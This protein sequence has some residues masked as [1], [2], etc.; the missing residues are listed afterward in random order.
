MELGD[1]WLLRKQSKL[2]TLP[3]TRQKASHTGSSRGGG[4]RNGSG[5]DMLGGMAM[6]HD[7]KNYYLMCRRLRLDPCESTKQ[8][9]QS[10]CL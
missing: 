8:K 10:M 7:F 6:I 4:V 2:H 3:R 5:A 9:E 1:L